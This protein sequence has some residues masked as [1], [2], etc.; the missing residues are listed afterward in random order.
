VESVTLTRAGADGDRRFF[1]IDER[2]RMLNAKVHG[3][4][5]S[6]L[7]DW[8][9]DARRLTL[10]FPGGEIVTGTAGAGPAISV[11][12]FSRTTPGRLVSG[13]WSEAISGHAGANLRLVEA[14]ADGYRG[15]AVDRGFRG[16]VS[17]ISVASLRR[18]TEQ[19]DGI[20][21]I[22]SR[23]F[24]MLVEI[25][26]V[27]PHAEDAWIGSSVQIGEALVRFEGNVGRCLV[28]GRDPDTGVSD[29]PTL[30]LLGAYRRQPGS[31]E[32]LPFGIYGQVLQGGAI[33][34]GDP[35]LPRPDRLP[36]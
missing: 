12:F 26:G 9:G 10:T 29:L 31:T 30:D 16:A 23:R 34:I 22:D 1:V 27:A 4:L 17:L 19:G 7:A 36:G 32:P 13:P 33:R 2:D 20:G 14:V 8:D 24:R 28:T 3:S 11:G 15:S 21:A 35:I 25:D 18:L 6:V 5:Q